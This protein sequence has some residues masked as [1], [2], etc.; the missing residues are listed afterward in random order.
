MWLTPNT[1]LKE[2]MQDHLKQHPIPKCENPLT[3]EQ[4]QWKY[5]GFTAEELLSEETK[6][7]N[8]ASR[9]EESMKETI[10]KAGTQL[11]DD[12]FK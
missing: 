11:L 3:E 9:I 6:K 4:S 8:M 12:R 10:E 7:T 1:S 5:T 2:I